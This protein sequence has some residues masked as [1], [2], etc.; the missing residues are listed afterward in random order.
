MIGRNSS[1][2]SP[3]HVQVALQVAGNRRGSETGVEDLVGARKAHRDR[4]E[5]RLEVAALEVA[6]GRVD[7]EIEECRRAVGAA[8]EQIA[9]AT[10]TGERGLRDGRREAGRHDRV[11]R[12]PPGA[13]QLRGGLRH[14]RMARGG[15]TA[16]EAA[17]R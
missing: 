10:E 3:V 17:H 6:A 1:A 9:P 16:L 13:Q 5:V 12:V 7:E 2:E 8:R 11:E 4:N 15:H 14:A